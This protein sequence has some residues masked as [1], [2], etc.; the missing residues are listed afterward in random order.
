MN[1]QSYLILIAVFLSTS[2]SNRSTDPTHTE[3]DFGNSVKKLVN[4]QTYH[5]KKSTYSNRP[6]QQPEI[7]GITADNA[8]R[9]YRNN[10]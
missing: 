4:S 10:Q 3:L 1:H 5:K 2:C 9:A 7:D 6:S 8:I